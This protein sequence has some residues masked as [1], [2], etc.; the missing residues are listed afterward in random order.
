M[1]SGDLTIALISGAGMAGGVACL[2][3]GLLTWRSS[4]RVADIPTSAISG[5]A[6]GEIRL[7]GTVQPVTLTL[8]SPLQSR[9]CLYYRARVR[10]GSGRNETTIFSEE[11]A[12]GF[13][14][15]D[16]S[17]TIRVLPRAAHWEVPWTWQSSTA[18]LGEEPPELALN[19]G[20]A[21]ADLTLDHAAQ[22]RALLTVHD[23]TTPDPQEGTG[24]GTWSSL[25]ATG[26][27]RHYEEA[28]LEPG[29]TVTI[30]GSALPYSDVADPATADLF[31]PTIA[32]SDPEVVADLASA[33]AAGTLEAD[34][35]VAWGNAAIPGFGIGQP[36]RPPELDPAARPE[37]VVPDASTE[38]AAAAARFEIPADALVVAAMPGAPLTIYA[39]SP[40]AVTAEARGGVWL[41]L[42]GVVVLV[43]SALALA[44]GV[45]AVG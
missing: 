19:R 33:R 25:A 31:D 12:A 37:T 44:F 3:R 10:Q 35:H 14:L 17:G 11:R 27:A 40:A 30:V 5:L 20:S 13:A 7:A 9:P 36:T 2:V 21:V 15:V 45:G 28:R 8:V 39:G 4:E 16:D 42:A 32:L 43:V 6:A 38:E 22:V 23:P 26:G 24:G 1:A 41:A 18:L 34:P 29:Q